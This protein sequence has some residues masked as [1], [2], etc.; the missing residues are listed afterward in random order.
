MIGDVAADGN[1]LPVLQISPI[2]A[3]TAETAVATEAYLALSLQAAEEGKLGL[4]T[5]EFDVGKTEATARFGCLVRSSLDGFESDYPVLRV[6]GTTTGHSDKIHYRIDLSGERFRD[7]S[8]VDFRLYFYSSGTKEPL[9]FDGIRLNGEV[10][11]AP[12]PGSSLV[13]LLMFTAI[14]FLIAAGWAARQRVAWSYA[15][16]GPSPTAARC[17]PW[18]EQARDAIFDIIDRGRMR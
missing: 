6:D 14:L 11:A 13:W 9:E 12:E 16:R 4:Q 5:L 17:E 1:R 7:L 15:T 18:S 8:E 10:I 2:E 3:D